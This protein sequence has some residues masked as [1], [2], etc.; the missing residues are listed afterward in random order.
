MV[1]RDGFIYVKGTAKGFEKMRRQGA[2]LPPMRILSKTAKKLQSFYTG[3]LDKLDLSGIKSVLDAEPMLFSVVERLRNQLKEVPFQE[4]D[5]RKVLKRSL[6][7]TTRKFFG[8][9]LLDAPDHIG[10]HV[11]WSLNKDD[12]FKDRIEGVK[13]YYLDTAV[14]KIAEGQDALRQKFIDSMQ[15][16]LEGDTQDMAGVFQ[17]MKD[18][19]NDGQTFSKF[20]ARDQFARYNKA[21]TLASFQQAGIDKVKWLTCGDQRVR[22]THK[23]LNGKV[24]DADNLPKEID[25]YNCRCALVPVED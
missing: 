20:F 24:F 7:E 19:K 15:G 1:K 3:F 8:D 6:N 16:W 22:P 5:Y 11:K 21:L 17:I 9:F 25:D 13:E 4:T 10:V 14:E 12:V 23:A 2:I 18:I